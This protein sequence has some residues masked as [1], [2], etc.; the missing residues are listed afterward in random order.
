MRKALT[1]AM[2]AWYFIVF[3]RNSDQVSTVGPFNHP[4][5]CTYFRTWAVLLSEEAIYEPIHPHREPLPA[6]FL[7]RFG[8]CFETQS[9]PPTS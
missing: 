1:M 8:P 9:P 3:S 2:L 4:D 5:T 6:N 7:S